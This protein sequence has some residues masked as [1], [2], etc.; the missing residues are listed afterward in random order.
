RRFIS[1][2]VDGLFI[3]P[4]YR[5]GSEARIYK[6]LLSRG[7]PTVVLGHTAAFCNQFVCVESDDVAASY[8]ITQH[9]LKLGHKRIA[10]LTGPSMTPWNQERLA[11]YRRALREADLELEDKL[12]FEAG[13]TIE[14][15]AKAAEQML[16]ETL[17]ATAVQAIN[18]VV[19]AGAGET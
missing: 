5:M 1:R 19:A 9:L 12:I 10:F 3:A 4:V 2:R 8:A 17:D 13:R 15:G 6:E 7:I 11:G 14:E 16:S 18:D